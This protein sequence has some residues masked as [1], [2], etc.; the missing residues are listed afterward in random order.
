MDDFRIGCLTHPAVVDEA[1]ARVLALVAEADAA[2]ALLDRIRWPS[3][4]QDPASDL[5][6]FCESCAADA[7]GHALDLGSVA[8]EMAAASRDLAGRRR[9]VET[10]FGR[11]PATQLG[12]FMA[13]RRSRVTSAVARVVHALRAQGL[14]VGYDVFSPA[15]AFTVGQDLAGLPKADLV[16]AMTYLDA[17]GP[18]SLPFE[19]AGY[20]RWLEAMGEPA[21]GDVLADLSG[22]RL[23]PEGAAPEVRAD[24]LGLEARRLTAAVGDAGVMGLDVV[25]L[26]GVLSIGDDLVRRRVAAIRRAGIGIAPSWD[27]RL[28]S[29]T[30]LEAIATAWAGGASPE[31]RP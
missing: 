6:C 16:K 8:A 10:I 18:A 22:F 26:P 15:I 3:P 13:W 9:V 17:A 7:V 20:G 30:R 1:V 11:H 24:I 4:S 25:V 19:L 12:R 2:G 27:L 5:C 14:L 28:M 21:A 31:P 29:G 23:A